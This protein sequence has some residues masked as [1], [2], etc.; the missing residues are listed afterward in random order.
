MPLLLMNA[1]DNLE[2]VFIPQLLDLHLYNKLIHLNARVYDH[3]LVQTY[4]KCGH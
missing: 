3:L 4:A 2:L 1:D